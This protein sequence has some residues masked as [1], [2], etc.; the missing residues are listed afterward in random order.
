MVLDLF[1]TSKPCTSLQKAPKQNSPL[2]LPQNFGPL[3]IFE[4][5]N[6]LEIFLLFFALKIGNISEIIYF[7]QK[8][9]LHHYK[10]VSL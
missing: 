3:I 10:Q 7:A 4:K 5:L 6:F 8:T 1:W 9:A 2:I